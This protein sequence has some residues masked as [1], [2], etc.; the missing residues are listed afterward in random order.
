MPESL[1]TVSG[2]TLPYGVVT[3]LITNS[4]WQGGAMITKP[5]HGIGRR[6]KIFAYKL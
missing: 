3:V 6:S 1:V 5:S 2:T 4:L